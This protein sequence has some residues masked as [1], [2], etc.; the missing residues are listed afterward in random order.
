MEMDVA[1]RGHR[2]S[3][4]LEKPPFAAHEPHLA[5]IDRVAENGARDRDFAS[6]EGAG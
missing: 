1:A 6:G 3:S 4:R 5:I 2:D